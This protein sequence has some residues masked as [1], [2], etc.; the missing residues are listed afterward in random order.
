MSARP[1]NAT[2][3]AAVFAIVTVKVE[4]PPCGMIAGENALLTVTGGAMF[5]VAEAGEPLVAPCALVMLFAAIVLTY[6]FG[7]APVA[8][9]VTVQVAPAAMLP[10]VS[11]TTDP[12]AAPVT[13]PEQV[14]A[15][16]GAAATVMPE[17]NE[18]ETATEVRADAPAPVLAIEIVKV[19]VPFE[20]IVTG[21]N[22]FVM[23][24]LAA[25]L[26]VKVAVPG[27]VFVA[28]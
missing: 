1:V 9:T 26:T 21:E 5:N 4:L 22:D 25:L 14:V 20:A 6:A 28:P 8:E 27:L 18:S 24:T 11:P 2:A 19:E 23:V 13:V 12:P 17:G 10:P 15:K 7:T 16:F 3:C